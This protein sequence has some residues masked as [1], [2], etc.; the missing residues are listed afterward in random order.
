MIGSA[1]TAVFVVLTYWFLSWKDKKE[2]LAGTRE[3]FSGDTISLEGG[4]L[5][6]IE[7]PGSIVIYSPQQKAKT[8][9]IRIRG[10]IEYPDGDKI[11][12]LIVKSGRFYVKTVVPSTV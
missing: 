8:S 10:S 12:V 3:L 9:R 4:G 6:H 7:D 5:I 2:L 1:I 11:V